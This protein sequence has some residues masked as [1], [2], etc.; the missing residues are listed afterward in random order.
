VTIKFSK[1]KFVAGCQ[2]SKRLYWQVD[3][4]GLA[5]APS[6]A[7]L[8]VREQEASSSFLQFG[9]EGVADGNLAR[10]LQSLGT[11]YISARAAILAITAWL[12]A[13]ANLLRVQKIGIF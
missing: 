13:N 1:S 9:E 8:V 5:A 4:P 11:P 2:C 3:E 6:A 10:A 7:A 12:F